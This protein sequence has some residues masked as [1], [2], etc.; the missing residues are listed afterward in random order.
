MFQASSSM[1]LKSEMETLEIGD[2]KGS[3]FI[4]EDAS[5]I[6]LSHNPQVF[7]RFQNTTIFLFLRNFKFSFAYLTPGWLMSIVQGNILHPQVR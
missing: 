2:D 3:V 1:L 6:L 7:R 4:F 5:P